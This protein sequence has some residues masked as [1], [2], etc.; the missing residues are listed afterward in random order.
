L[1]VIRETM[2]RM[3]EINRLTWEDVNLKERDIVLYTRKKKGGSLTPRK[4]PMTNKLYD[5][6]SRRYDQRDKCKPWVFWH[7]YYSRRA[8]MKVDGPYI[9]RNKL[10]K[11]LCN[12]AGV[13][14]F[15]YHAMR[16]S[17]AS[18]MNNANVPIPWIQKIL[19]HEKRC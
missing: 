18:V 5:V 6:L 1:W 8:G 14:Y 9:D 12:R 2:G 10:M 17:G 13:K 7:R 3:S 15:R 11:Y 4:V 16:H 19:G